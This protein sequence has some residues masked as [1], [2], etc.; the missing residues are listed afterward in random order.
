MDKSRFHN[1]VL[2]EKKIKMKEERNKLK[3]M[4]NNWI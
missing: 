4:F 2:F 3:V 1:L